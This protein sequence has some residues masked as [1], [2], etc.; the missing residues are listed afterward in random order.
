MAGLFVALVVYLDVLLCRKL[1]KR[2]GES[3]VKIFK[4]LPKY[5]Q[6][7]L[8]AGKFLDI[9]LLFLSKDAENSGISYCI[10]VR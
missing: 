6:D 10:A 7:P 1:V 9:L 8:L 4:L 5:V 3:Q 2:P